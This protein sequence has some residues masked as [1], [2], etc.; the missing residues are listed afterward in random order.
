MIMLFRSGTYVLLR[1][2]SAAVS[3]LGSSNFKLML[4]PRSRLQQKAGLIFRATRTHARNLAKFATIYKATCMLLKN[5]GATPGK[6]GKNL[7]LIGER[8]GGFIQDPL[9][10]TIRPLR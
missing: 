8:K 7:P 1:R 3:P 2:V 9:T 10:Q 4:S 6:E 5:Y